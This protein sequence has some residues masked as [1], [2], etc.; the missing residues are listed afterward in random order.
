LAVGELT[1]PRVIQSNYGLFVP[2]TFRSL[3]RK[4]L[5][6]K[7]PDTIQSVTWLTASWFVGELSCNRL[8]NL[9][10]KQILKNHR[11]AILYL[12]TEPNPN[13][14]KNWH[15]TNSEINQKSDLEKILLQF[16]YQMFLVVIIN[17]R[18][19]Q[20]LTWLTASLFVGELYGYL[21]FCLFIENVTAA[22][23]KKF[24]SWQSTS[25]MTYIVSG[26]A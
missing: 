23:L 9:I 5:G 19:D 2:K 12:H 3:E 13:P 18:V 8:V 21:P 10:A 26:G 4:V 11:K 15:C 24:T 14:V 1:S 6:T 7:S 20:C 25:E 16:L 17:P 22:L